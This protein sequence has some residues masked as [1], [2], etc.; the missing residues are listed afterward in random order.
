MPSLR[1]RLDNPEDVQA[2]A[3]LREFPFTEAHF[4]TVRARV[5]DLTGIALSEAK[6]DLVYSRLSR[7]LRVLRLRDFDAYLAY[8]E[9]HPEKEN[10]EFINA[11]TTN[12]TAFF[13]E[14]HHFVDLRDRV[15]PELMRQRQYERRIRIWSAGCSTGEEPYSLAIALHEAL[16]SERK[17]WDA[18][19][20]ATDIDTGV[21]ATASR[22]QYRGDRLKG[23]SPEQREKHFRPVSANANGDHVARDHLKES[24][25][26]RQL[27]LNG[28]WPM[29]GRFDV[30]FC[31]NV[32]IYF[33][34]PTQQVL[35]NRI[36]G[37][38]SPGAHL[39]IGH[40]ENL[41]RICER[42]QHLGRTIHQLVEPR[43]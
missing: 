18:L 32:V 26:F 23:L 42:F 22:G 30:V 39:Y 5:R 34:K 21:L 35:F 12:L 1:E 37:Q 43:P 28:P 9:G 17:H 3:G 8:L 2:A 38:M 36:A 19:I 16:G 6:H 15:L 14:A 7:R 20:L 25:R 4:Q 27:N 40:S 31:R 24:I 10:V 41:F 11:L 29:K 33:D 13:R